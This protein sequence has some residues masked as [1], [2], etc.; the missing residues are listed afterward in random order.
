MFSRDRILFFNCFHLGLVESSEE[1]GYKR[2]LCKVELSPVSL[3]GLLATLPPHFLVHFP[4]WRLIHRRYIH[5]DPQCPPP[6]YMRTDLGQFHIF[7]GNSFT[8]SL[9][10]CVFILSLPLKKWAPKGIVHGG[11]HKMAQKHQGRVI[12]QCILMF[13]RKRNISDLAR[14]QGLLYL[15]YATLTL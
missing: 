7:H 5:P 11:I 14:S 1:Y 12:I 9:N 4:T 6:H 2:G 3:D 8:T 15:P 10:P 13:S